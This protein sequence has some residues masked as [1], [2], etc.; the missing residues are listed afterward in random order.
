MYGYHI[1]MYIYIYPH[2][3]CRYITMFPISPT[4]FSPKPQW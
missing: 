1:T 3:L 2:I 4:M